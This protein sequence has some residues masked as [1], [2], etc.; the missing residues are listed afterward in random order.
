[1]NFKPVTKERWGDF[2][3]L[4]GPNGAYSGCWCMWWR[5][6]RS[7]YDRNGNSGNRKAMKN[8]VKAEIVPGSASGGRSKASPKGVFTDDPRR[9][10]LKQIVLPTGFHP[11]P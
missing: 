10:E 9:H 6:T 5:E 4:F 11:A 1:M 3:K 2:E 8:L 7:E